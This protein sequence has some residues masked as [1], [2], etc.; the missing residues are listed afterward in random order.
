MPWPLHFC[1]IERH[2]ILNAFVRHLAFDIIQQFMFDKEHG[3][4]VA[5]C[6]FKHALDIIRGSRHDHFETGDM[7]IPGLEH[8]RVLSGSLGASSSWHTYD[9]GQLRLP[10]KHVAQLGG[11]VD[12]QIAGE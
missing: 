12:D 6:R 8:L 4:R 5:H 9:Q 7:G 3:I 10:A 11:T 2:G 1:A